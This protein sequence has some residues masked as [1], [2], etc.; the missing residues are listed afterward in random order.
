MNRKRLLISRR[1]AL[2]SGAATA[3]LAALPARAQGDGKAEFDRLVAA[4]K[5]E[6]AVAVGGGRDASAR[7]FILKAWKKDF[8][9]I[10]MQF[11]VAGGFNWPNQVRAERASGKYLWDVYLNGPNVL[12]YRMAQ[13]GVFQDLLP[14]LVLPDL[15]DPKTWRRSFDDMFLDDEK[16][17]FSFFASVSTVW[18]HANKVPPEKVKAQ[19]LK[20]LLDPA[21]Q[22]RIGWQDPRGGGPGANYAVMVEEI[23]GRDALKTIIVDQKSVFY[24]RQSQ[25]TEAFIRGKCD[26]LLGIEISDL[27]TYRKAG[28]KFDVRPFGHDAKTA[29]LSI[30]G[31]FLALFD[32]PPHPNAAKL[33]AN[34][35]LTRD[36]QKGYAEAYQW[37]SNR[38]DV[39]PISPPDQ[40]VVAG[41]K[42]IEP[43]QG[44][45][46]KRKAEVQEFIRTLRPS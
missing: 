40:Q 2:L 35:V 30:S 37:D 26:I 16:R 8:P 46:L 10:E 15:K 13:E 34:W 5:Q 4:A 1:A 43:Q 29:H 17:M 11:T 7:D 33:L 6:G 44:R 24:D 36:V 45:W 25:A 19:G 23:L 31:S 28:V 41:D 20:L 27:E 38:A 18:Y 3:A 32:K 14:A 22:G 39:A 9:D 42:Y 21:Y 12:V